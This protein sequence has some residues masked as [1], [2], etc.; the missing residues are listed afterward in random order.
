MRRLL[1]CALAGG[2]AAVPAVVLGTG[3]TPAAAQVGD[4]QVNEPVL[5]GAPSSMWQTNNNVEALAVSRGIVFA[6]GTFTRVRPPGA[7]AGQNETTRTYL[8]AFNANTGALLTNFNLQPNAR[9][10]DLSVSPDGSRLYVVGAFTRISGT[11]R[12]RVAAITI[13]TTPTGSFSLVSGF[14]PNLSGGQVTA[15]DATATRVYASGN[16]TTVNGTSKPYMVSLNATN[17]AIDTAFNTTLAAPPPSLWTPAPSPGALAVEVAPDGSRVLIGG[18]FRTVNGQDIGGMAS[19]NPVTGA[20]EPWQANTVQ[21]TNTNCSGRVTDI[22]ASGD[23]A[24]V[25]GE[26]DPPGCYEGTYAA[27][28]SD[29]QM[30]WNSPCLGASLGLAIMDDVLYKASHQH[31]CAFSPGDAR[32]GYVGGTDRDSFIWY[33]LVAQ[34]IADG[35]FVHWA[36]NTN[37]VTGSNPVGPHVLATD[38]TQ[39][40]VGGDFTRVNN[41]NQ[42]GIA[43]FGR[44][45]NIAPNR[46]AAPS[47]ISTG[48][49]E[50]TVSWPAV[51]DPDDGHLTYN[52][53]RGNT[54]LSSQQVESYPWSRPVM[55]FVDRNR[56]VGSTQSY[57]LRV[58]DG[59]TQAAASASTSVVVRGA[60][61]Q[62]YG[63]LVRSY[64][65]SLYWDMGGSGSTVADGST[66]GANAGELIGSPTRG[67]GV[68]SSSQ[69][70]QLNGS[71]Q[72]VTSASQQSLSASFT[73]SVWV[74]GTT[75]AGGSL[76]AVTD[77]KTGDGS[78]SD[79]ALTMDNNGNIVFSVH[80]PPRPG[81]P[82]PLGPGLNNVRLQGPIYNDGG[83]HHVVASWDNATGTA[84]LYIDG[85]LNGTYVGTAGGLTSGYYRVGYTDLAEEQAVFGRN[86]YNL[87][88]P[89]SEYFS[90]GVDE[91][92]VF[93]SAL[94]ATQVRELFSA[95][96]SDAAGS[97]NAAPTASFTASV[98]GTSVSFDASASTDDTGI[99]SYAWNFGDGTTGT[100]RTTSHTYAPGSYTATL[101]VTDGG[102]LTSTTTRSFTVA[103]EP[104]GET[105]TVVIEN[106]SAWRWRYAAGAPPTGW[107]GRT[108]V[109]TTWSSGNAIFGWGT[110]VS[111]SL[112][113]FPDTADRPR[114][115]YF[116]RSFQVTD[117]SRV[118]RLRLTSVA[119]DG[120]V[121]YV[122]GT[123]VTRSNMPTGTITQN[124]YASS[125]R[126]AA[127]A[128]ASPVV[129]DVPVNLLVDGTNVVTAETH[130][131]YRNTR[132]V[133]FDLR[134]VLTTN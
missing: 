127:T 72:Y 47:A 11:V 27:R 5:S 130:V 119:N 83:W 112:D 73:Q 114:A 35:S 38:G 86:F 84:S 68:T 101:T 33:R 43:R 40:F 80:R 12:N 48:A 45:T 50:V 62:S 13:P 18:G 34:N 82:D 108:F 89:G 88:W 95:G 61:P 56:P 98:Q 3:P 15:V 65:A 124:S 32:G 109:D 19:L 39:M 78:M 42:Q 105:E 69:G 59:T 67:T 99:A 102:G 104:G 44:T 118:V 87:T 16:F 92:A 122:N 52:L 21:P 85:V 51:Y 7:A 77:V 37:A 49:G 2:V 1:A 93:P 111:T 115:A 117:A 70:L 79:R 106:G 132:D 100:G 90:G 36:P 94:S 123:E 23:T 134:A 113:I 29:G 128:N 17:G 120:V 71:S 75:I 63:D 129:V 125:A 22:I 103:E 76:M 46:P 26:G 28:I 57:F 4:N 81:S 58:T 24:Y 116:R 96:M 53:Y 91:V 30:R 25:T 66:G 14:A 131:N 110:P 9:V 74:R 133:A 41:T 6:G 8:A 107:T 20:T 10:R 121:I 31:D 55:R 97:T 126:N 60:D 54:L 64:G